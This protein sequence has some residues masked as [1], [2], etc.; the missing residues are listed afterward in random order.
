MSELSRASGFRDISHLYLDLMFNHT[1][2]SITCSY[3]YTVSTTLCQ[4]SCTSGRILLFILLAAEHQLC[5]RPTVAALAN[6]ISARCNW[7]WEFEALILGLRVLFLC[8]VS[9]ASL[10]KQVTVFLF[11]ELSFSFKGIAE[12]SVS[13]K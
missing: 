3:V 11:F 12:I 5:L 8:L 1:I 2:V 4:T 9:V 6:Y 10:V 7:S 13:W